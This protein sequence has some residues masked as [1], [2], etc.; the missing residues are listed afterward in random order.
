[1]TRSCA[2][3][4]EM[5]KQSLATGGIVSSSLSRSVRPLCRLITGPHVA[6]VIIEWPSGEGSLSIHLGVQSIAQATRHMEMVRFF[7][8]S[9][10]DAAPEGRSS[11]YRCLRPQM[12]HANSTCGSRR[13]GTDRK[14]LWSRAHTRRAL[15]HVCVDDEPFQEPARLLCTAAAEQGVSA[16]AFR[17]GDTWEV[18]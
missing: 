6:F 1:M 13:V 2:L 18:L 16:Q 15:E 7:K 12:V 11:T 10:E 3:S 4:L 14:D 5:L 9:R 8:R 17:A